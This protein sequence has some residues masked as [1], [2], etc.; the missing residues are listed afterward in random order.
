LVS[1]CEHGRLHISPDAGMIELLND[2]MQ[3][4]KPGDE[5]KVYCTGFLN[6]DQPLIRYDIGDT[7]IASVEPCSCGRN[8]PL[9]KEICG[10]NEDVI[11]G[12]DGRAMVRFHS[13]FNGLRTVKQA[14]VIQE[15]LN[16]IYI[17]ALPDGRIA[18][19]EIALMQNRIKSQ[20]GDVEVIVEE[21]DAIPLTENGKFKA[22][23]SKLT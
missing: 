21:V 9:V 2:E 12:K 6:Y 7:M 8:M 17:K 5:G 11:V 14:Q 22:V 13:I 3:P 20:L 16:L 1:E 23:I 18:S 19:D 4:V 15:S 10:R